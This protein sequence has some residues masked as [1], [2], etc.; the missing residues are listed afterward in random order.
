[1]EFITLECVWESDKFVLHERTHKSEIASHDVEIEEK[2][3]T[4]ASSVRYESIES[5]LG[6]KTIHG[7]CSFVI[8]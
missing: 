2:T 5:F 4:Q 8:T 6:G 3:S 7:I 1:M